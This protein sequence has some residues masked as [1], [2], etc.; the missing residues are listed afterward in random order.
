MET[1]RYLALLIVVMPLG[2]AKEKSS[3]TATTSTNMGSSSETSTSTTSDPGNFVEED[4]VKPTETPSEIPTIPEPVEPIPAEPV[5]AVKMLDVVA[6]KKQMTADQVALGD[7]VVNS[8]GMLLVPIPA[9]DF[10]MGSPNSDGSARSGEKPQHPVKITNP[11]YLGVY[12]VT[13]AQ[14]EKVM[15]ARPWQQKKYVKEGPDYPAAYVTWANAV[16]FCRK[17]SEEEGVEYLLPTEAQWEYACRAGTTTV[18]SFGD[19]ESELEQYAWYDENAF[20]T[21]QDYAH[22]VGQKLPNPWSLYD[23]HGN[24]FE[25]CRDATRQYSGETVLSDPA[26]PLQAREG[27]MRGGAFYSLSNNTRSADRGGRFQPVPRNVSL[28]FRVV[29]VISE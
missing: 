3:A 21:S 27:V 4:A 17:L 2:C 6:A 25:W 9:G 28:G 19:D 5:P 11:F 12:E 16:E 24:V 23:M 20:Y 22:L 29:R 15:E 10:Q 1:I 13:Q 26:G 14:Y 18:Y 7:P 8:V